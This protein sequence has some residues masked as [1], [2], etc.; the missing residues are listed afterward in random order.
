VLGTFNAQMR[1]QLSRKGTQTPG[2][3][4]HT[5]LF[6]HNGKTEIRCYFA[7]SGGESIDWQDFV[8]EI[9][10]DDSIEGKI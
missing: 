5:K 8:G 9:L 6:Q 10:P 1:A 2:K 7:V 4:M 3:I